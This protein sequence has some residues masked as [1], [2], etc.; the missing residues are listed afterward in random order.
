MV[1]NK[2]RSAEMRTYE[3]NYGQ[4]RPRIRDMILDTTIAGLL[5][6]QIFVARLDSL[7]EAAS[8]AFLD[9]LDD[10]EKRTAHHYVQKADQVADDAWQQIVQGQQW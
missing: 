6:E 3:P 2:P 4:A 1:P 10:S 9:T 7:A 8:T 5:P